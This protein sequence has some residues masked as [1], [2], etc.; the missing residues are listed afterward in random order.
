[1]SPLRLLLDVA[2]RSAWRR[3]LAL[4]EQSWLLLALI[5]AFLAGYV[6][7]AFTLFYGGL[8]FLSRFPGLGGL[9]VERLLY[10]LFAFLFALLLL[11][12]LVI[13]YTNLFRNRETAF[14]LTLPVPARTVLQWKLIE[15]TILASWAFV[16]LIAPL[17][18]AYGLVHRVDWHFYPVVF[19]MVAL[20]V[21]LPGIAGGWMAIVVARFLDRKGFQILLVS[22]LLALI[23]VVFFRFRPEPITDELLETRVLAVIDRLLDNTRFAQFPLLPSYWLSASVQN[24]SEGAVHTALFFALV[25]LSYVLF[26][27][28]LAARH[29]GGAFYEASSVVHSRGSLFSRWAW[30]QRLEDR[31]RGARRQSLLLRRGPRDWLDTLLAWP[32]MMPSDVR[33]LVAKDLRVFWRD[34]T[35]WGQTLMLFGLLSVYIINLRHFTRQLDSPFWISLV[36]YLNLGACALNLATLTTRFVC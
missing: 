35:Q 15:S 34:T 2:V 36:S 23:A 20:F 33:A 25:L 14:L 8:R 4:R 27:G 11:S 1:M 19:S 26:L 24:W 31:R 10:L 32:G 13:G 6:V 17:L 29:L 30:F 9:L 5:T 16:F 21:V 7:L 28:T 3:L 18:G 12:N 22:L